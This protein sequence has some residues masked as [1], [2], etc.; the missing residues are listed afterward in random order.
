[1][2]GP[3]LLIETE[4]APG[5]RLEL[6]PDTLRHAVSVLRL[7]DGAACRVFDGRGNEHNAT[8]TLSGRRSGSV[9]LAGIATP[10]TT[11]TLPLRLLQGI[12]RGDHMD[13]AIQKAVELGATE[14][15]P[16][17]SV[18]SLSGAGH[19]R[20][21][22]KLQHW[23]GVLNAAAEQCG[24]N[25]LPRLLDPQDL[26]AALQVLPAPGMRIVADPGGIDPDV[27]RRDHPDPGAG[28]ISVLVGPE[29][30]LDPE[31]VEHARSLGF[32]GLRLGPRILRTETA[33]IVAL[34][35]LQTF[36]GDLAHAGA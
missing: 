17:L 33:S 26:L 27:L 34:T 12:A 21:A 36:Y 24:R 16:V 20:L 19:R 10:P 28:T 15:W 35:V 25:E 29:G 13:L 9:Q 23:R 30:G 22:S 2:R 6:P 5:Q 32:L 3:R 18:R 7:R 11:P 4:L 8:L 31:E 14:I 1:M